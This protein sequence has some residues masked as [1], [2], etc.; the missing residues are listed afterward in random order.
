M[1]AKV[2]RAVQ[3]YQGQREIFS[4]VIRLSLLKIM[5]KKSFTVSDV[6]KVTCHGVRLH[7]VQILV[8]ILLEGGLITN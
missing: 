3:S 1:G 2:V 4:P 7:S 5:H 8:Q 6:A